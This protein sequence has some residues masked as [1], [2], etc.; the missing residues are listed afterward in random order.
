MAQIQQFTYLDGTLSLDASTQHVDHGVSL[1]QDCF[2]C[3]D[4][5][6]LGN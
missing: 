1:A 6:T 2:D 4:I 5:E 3:Y